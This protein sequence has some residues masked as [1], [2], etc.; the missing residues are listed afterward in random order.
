MK[1]SEAGQPD[2]ALFSLDQA[3]V[4][5]RSIGRPEIEAQLWGYKVEVLRATTRHTE[6][7][8]AAR[9]ALSI[10]ERM[11]PDSL[12]VSYGLH[13]LASVTSDENPEYEPINRRALAI[14]QRLAP[15]S[16]NEA[17]SL[18]NL[19]NFANLHGDSRAAVDLTLR[20]LSINQGL[21]PTSRTVASNHINLCWHHMNRGE[22]AAADDSCRRALEL[23]RTLG[24]GARDGVRQALHNMGVVARLYGDYDR[25]VQL[26][27]Q[28]RELCDQIAPEGV[29]AGFN[30]FE[31]GVTEIERRN[32]ERAESH[33]RRSEE[34]LNAASPDD[35]IHAPMLAIMRANIAYQRADLAG[36][37]KLLR[38]ALA[39]FEKSLPGSIAAS[40][41]LND[42]GRVLR[43]RGQ[44]REAEVCLRRALALR[45]EYGPGST[46]TAQSSHNLGLLLWTTGRL[47][48]AE[49]EL[50]RAIEDLEAQ[51]DK[52]GGS[53]N[54][55]RSS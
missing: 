41:T 27:V 40:M 52:L 19:A 43:E 6:G 2:A 55:C 34:I 26:F 39:D 12:A 54:P 15:G 48:E 53:R 36:A 23:Y 10:R 5:A 29:A 50:R 24:P 25:S 4:E 45:R 33:L 16:R 3:L 47:A 31:L 9:Q 11:A 49:V 20:A 22:L 37:E 28:E 8:S 35:A 21:D 13:E 44:E 7:Q 18:I 42:L 38:Q 17:N 51:Q 1:Q 46:E 14:R 30:A 32:L